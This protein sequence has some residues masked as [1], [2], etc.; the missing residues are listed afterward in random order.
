MG[1]G[2]MAR[3]LVLGFFAIGI[4]LALYQAFAPDE[5]AGGLTVIVPELSAQTRQGNA[6]FDNTCATCHGTNAAGTDAGPP[7]V[8]D[9]YNPGHHPDSSFLSA[10]RN[11]VPQHHWPFGNMPR[12]E[13]VSDEDVVKIVSYVRELQAANGIAYRPHNM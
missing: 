6:L 5:T 11:G 1:S 10:V 4:A 7:L 9:I 3:N 8:H 12:Q 13:L 2:N